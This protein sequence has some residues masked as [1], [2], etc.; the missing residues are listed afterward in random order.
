M[1][2]FDCV[3]LAEEECGGE[4]SSGGQWAFLSSSGRSS[5]ISPQPED[6]KT[7]NQAGVLFVQPKGCVHSSS[8]TKITVFPTQSILGKRRGARGRDASKTE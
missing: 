5:C 4:G 6:A 1:L 8:P 3:L 7:V 2:L